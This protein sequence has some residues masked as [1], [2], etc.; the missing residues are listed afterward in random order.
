MND[1]PEVS[2]ESPQERSSSG[3]NWR[4][5]T[6]LPEASAGTPQQRASSGA[7]WKWVTNLPEV[8]GRRF[9]FPQT[10]ASRLLDESASH[11]SVGATL[12]D[13]R[14]AAGLLF[15]GAALFVAVD[16]AP[17]PLRHATGSLVHNAMSGIEH[18]V[19]PN[20]LL[21]GQVNKPVQTAAPS[22]AAAGSTS[23]FS[24]SADRSTTKQDSGKAAST[25]DS[26][27]VQGSSSGSQSDGKS[28]GGGSSSGSTKS[29]SS[30]G[31]VIEIGAP[32]HG[33]TSS[34][35]GSSS[36]DGQTGGGSSSGD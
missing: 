14:F 13:V 23:H 33:G 11:R 35:G 20:S 25:T 27:K 10:S 30:G 8:Q 17:T 32:A 28:T 2:G 3:A 12:T 9:G 21:P 26:A 5:V 1:S 19:L 29:S 15:A 4:W 6:S 34:G 36:G 16:L 24:G 7:N 18:I 31:P 22:T